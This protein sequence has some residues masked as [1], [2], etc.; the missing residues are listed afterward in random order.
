MPHLSTKSVRPY[1][2]ARWV[3]K[4]SRAN[5]FVSAKI[6]IRDKDSALAVTESKL[7]EI[8]RS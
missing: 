1:Y 8:D 7:D 6:P 3:A 4:N 5:V 2:A